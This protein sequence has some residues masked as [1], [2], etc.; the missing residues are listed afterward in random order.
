MTQ[1]LALTELTI[2]YSLPQGKPDTRFP[3]RRGEPEDRP[4]VKQSPQKGPTCTYYALAM[5][6]RRFGPQSCDF[7]DERRIE[8]S[9]SAFRKEVTALDLPRVQRDFKIM[10]EQMD[11]LRLKPD[12]EELQISSSL[13]LEKLSMGHFDR[14]ANVVRSFIS[15][16]ECKNLYQFYTHLVLE[17]LKMVHLKFFDS[18][19]VDPEQIY[20]AD[21]RLQLATKLTEDLENKPPDLLREA[22]DDHVALHYPSWHDYLKARPSVLNAYAMKVM[23]D[24]NGFKIS[25]WTPYQ[26]I[27]GLIRSLAEE[28]LLIVG[29]KLAKKHFP[30]SPVV[31]QIIEG[32]FIY[33][34]ENEY[35]VRPSKFLSTKK[36]STSH[37]VVI[38]GASLEGG[39]LVYLANPN[40]GS[41]PQNPEQQKIYCLS[42]ASFIARISDLRNS[43]HFTRKPASPFGYA[44]YY[45]QQA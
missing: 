11:N 34:W 35:A 9:C 7:P 15:Q 37:C 17:P 27:D 28:K 31:K 22:I 43:P 21:I 2:L 24:A 36:T 14:I 39:G 16:T 38:I 12:L 3:L 5:L 44:L 32:R 6:R 42:Y 26:R 41:D 1:L 25:S 45:P 8:A 33:G 20:L 4:R 23:A 40:D 18:M 19:G 10:E 13:L 29:G 30:A